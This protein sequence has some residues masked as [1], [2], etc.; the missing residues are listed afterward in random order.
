M[1]W[2]GGWPPHRHEYVCRAVSPHIQFQAVA[3]GIVIRP[4]VLRTRWYIVKLSNSIGVQDRRPGPA[5]CVG[6][7]KQKT[8]TGPLEPDTLTLKLRPDRGTKAIEQA[9]LIEGCRETCQKDRCQNRQGS[10][11][12]LPSLCVIGYTDSTE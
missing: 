4:E 12:E 6:Q 7:M 3:I 2:L 1:D 5:L 8:L 11:G 9:E 10:H